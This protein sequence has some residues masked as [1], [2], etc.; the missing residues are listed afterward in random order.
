MINKTVISLISSE[1]NMVMYLYIHY[2]T[3]FPILFNRIDQKISVSEFQYC[4]A[5]HLTLLLR[6]NILQ[7]L[8]GFAAVINQLD[9]I[10]RGG[11]PEMVRTS[12][13]FWGGTP[14]AFW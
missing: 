7:I 5:L 10:E 9:F 8:R 12:V 13:L 1:N 11:K 2:L 4:G 6:F 14:K 3:S